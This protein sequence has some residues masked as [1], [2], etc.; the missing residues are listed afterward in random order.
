MNQLVSWCAWMGSTLEIPRLWL[1]YDYDPN[2]VLSFLPWTC[3]LAPFLMD[4]PNPLFHFCSVV[5]QR[6]SVCCSCCVILICSLTVE[7]WSIRF[8]PFKQQNLNWIIFILGLVGWLVLKVKANR[9]NCMCVYT[10]YWFP[11]S[12][13]LT[14]IHMCFDDE[15]IWQPIIV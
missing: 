4:I 14:L 15:F 1:Q 5:H 9:S 11:H 10:G 2:H 8:V 12:N 7:C 13:A 6:T 3:F